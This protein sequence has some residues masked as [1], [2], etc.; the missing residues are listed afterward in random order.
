MAV[1]KMIRIR[2]HDADRYSTFADAASAALARHGGELL[3]QNE[4]D[5]ATR[6]LFVRFP[7]AASSWAHYGDPEIQQALSTANGSF[8]RDIVALEGGS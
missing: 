5:A 2:V 3:F 1:Y 8:T 4:R 7:D 6:I